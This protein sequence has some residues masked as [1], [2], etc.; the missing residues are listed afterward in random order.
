MTIFLIVLQ[1]LIKE[2]LSPL[3]KKL[4]T[5]AKSFGHNR[6]LS[7]DL[8]DIIDKLEHDI[9]FF[10]A[11]EEKDDASDSQKI[12][13][14]IERARVAAQ[15]VREK[16]KE[17]RDSGETVKCLSSLMF[18][19]TRFYTKLFEFGFPLLGRSYTETPENIIYYQAA[20]YFGEEI[21]DPLTGMDVD[22]RGVKEGQLN[23]R[24]QALSELIS[25]KS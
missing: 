1:K 9:L 14:L 24:L 6:A 17:P 8:K 15:D 13:L 11:S 5:K 12:R 4:A 19:T 23:S 3:S 18:H 20:R 16:H 22:I 21:F 2:Q 7:T 10:T 25:P